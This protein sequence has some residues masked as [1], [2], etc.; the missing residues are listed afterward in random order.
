MPPPST[1]H[2]EIL[3]PAPSW[4]ETPP[5]IAH[6]P[7]TP[8]VPSVS[9][10]WRSDTLHPETPVPTTA[11]PQL[12][13]RAGVLNAL[14]PF[15]R[16]RGKQPEPSEETV[17]RPRLDPAQVMSTALVKSKDWSLGVDERSPLLDEISRDWRHSIFLTRHTARKKSILL[18]SLLEINGCCLGPWHVNGRNGRS[19]RQLCR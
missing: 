15:R 19:T 2:D 8:T 17:K 13:W 16:L 11:T 7:D 4:N 9:K 1:T 18:Q 5:I 14:R 10:R 3:P 6:A 12:R